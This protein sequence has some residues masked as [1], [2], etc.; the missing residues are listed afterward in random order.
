M[1]P[2]LAAMIP[3]P[4]PEITPPVTKINLV[5]VFILG[6][7]PYLALPINTHFKCSLFLPQ[8]QALKT[9]YLVF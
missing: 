1:A 2:I 6:T 7:P 9:A 8:A 5:F 3:L 4:T